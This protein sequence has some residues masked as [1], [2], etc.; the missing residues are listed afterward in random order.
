LHSVACR[1]KGEA[2]GLKGKT[3]G[4]KRKALGLKDCKLLEKVLIVHLK[5]KN[6]FEH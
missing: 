4:L 2:F 6:A 5:L 3:F 1:F